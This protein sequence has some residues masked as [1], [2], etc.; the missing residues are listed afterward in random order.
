MDVSHPLARHSAFGGRNFPIN[1]IGRFPALWAGNLPMDKEGEFH[2]AE[3][4]S[5][6]HQACSLSKS[7]CYY[8]TLKEQLRIGTE[9][10]QDCAFRR[11]KLYFFQSSAYRSAIPAPNKH[12]GGGDDRRAAPAAKHLEEAWKTN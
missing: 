2:S 7:A 12:G 11:N 6:F 9:Q 4:Y 5:C 10:E 8:V 3:G 1:S